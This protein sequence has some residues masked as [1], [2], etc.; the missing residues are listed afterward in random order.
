MTRTVRQNKDKFER[1]SRNGTPDDPR[2]QTKKQ[3]GGRGNWGTI[4]DDVALAKDEVFVQPVHQRKLS[5]SSTH[6][7]DNQK[8][9][10]SEL[11]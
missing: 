6:S 3:G 10:L 7:N 2:Q 8:V 4:E 9:V 5:T 1:Q 11:L